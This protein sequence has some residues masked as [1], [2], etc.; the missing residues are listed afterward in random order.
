MLILP[1][2]EWPGVP[3]TFNPMLQF[4][5]TD[6]LPLIIRLLAPVPDKFMIPEV[7]SKERLWYVLPEI[8][9]EGVKVELPL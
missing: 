4:A 5:P 1:L 7:D 6:R 2:I 3:V 8:D 9:I